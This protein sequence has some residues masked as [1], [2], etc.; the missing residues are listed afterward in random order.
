MTDKTGL[1]VLDKGGFHGIMR[2][3]ES[4]MLD[5]LNDLS[6]IEKE[7]RRRVAEAPFRNFISFFR[8]YDD[9][10]VSVEDIT[11]VEEKEY[12]RLKELVA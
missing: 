8:K 12:D 11:E 9:G 4:A 5:N 7:N 1:I 2:R 10:K 6:T 3:Q